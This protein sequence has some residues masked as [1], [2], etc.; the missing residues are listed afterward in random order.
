MAALLI[1]GSLILADKAKQRK[2]EKKDKKKAHDDKRYKDLEKE[3]KLRLE[4]SQSGKVEKLVEVNDDDESD[5]ASGSKDGDDEQQ[6][7]QQQRQQRTPS[8]TEAEWAEMFPNELPLKK[9]P[10][11]YY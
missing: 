11:I 2:Q 10:I 4:R 7:Q 6:Q 9:K 1:G 8:Y 5:K 3:T